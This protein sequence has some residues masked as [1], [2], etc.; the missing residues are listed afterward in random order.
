[1][2]A[3]AIDIEKIRQNTL[4]EQ[5]HTREANRLKRKILERFELVDEIYLCLE[6]SMDYFREEGLYAAAELFVDFHI[7][8]TAWYQNYKR[9]TGDDSLKGTYE[10]IKHKLNLMKKRVNLEMRLRDKYYSN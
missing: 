10:S 2:V 8:T 4:N 5:L 6:K 9:L 3:S 1:M 7:E